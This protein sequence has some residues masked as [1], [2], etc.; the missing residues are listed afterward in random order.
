[1]PLNDKI[2]DPNDRF[3]ETMNIANAKH[4]EVIEKFAIYEYQNKVI[5]A[6]NKFLK[7]SYKM[8]KTNYIN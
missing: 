4:N 7:S 3:E 1:M 6:E 8:L 2:T 5:I